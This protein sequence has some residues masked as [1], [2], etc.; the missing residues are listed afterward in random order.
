MKPVKMSVGDILLMKKKHPCGSEAFTVLRVG[1]DI[2]IVCNSCKRDL[3]LNRE[4]IEKKIKKV[5]SPTNVEE[6]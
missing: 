1:S 6:T 2:R 5:I 4:V 3:T